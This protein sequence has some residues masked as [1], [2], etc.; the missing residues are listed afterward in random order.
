MLCNVRY[1][2]PILAHVQVHQ[3]NPPHPGVLKGG[4]C[5]GVVLHDASTQKII[6]QVVRAG[7]LLTLSAGSRSMNGV[8]I[9]RI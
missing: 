6:P 2:L 4:S 8:E 1:W 7:A 3:P 9:I 5:A